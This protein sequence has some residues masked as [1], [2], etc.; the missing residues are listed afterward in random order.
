MEGITTRGITMIKKAALIS[1]VTASAFAGSFRIDS[2]ID[3]DTADVVTGPQSNV[4]AQAWQNVAGSAG[5]L[6]LN[7]YA[8]VSCIALEPDDRLL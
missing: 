1:L 6:A 4:I 8:F 3:A 2:T 5:S 7:R